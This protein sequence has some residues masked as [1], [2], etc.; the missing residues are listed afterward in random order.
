MKDGTSAR[1]GPRGFAGGTGE[2]A[3]APDRGVTE[4]SEGWSVIFCLLT[5]RT[6][7]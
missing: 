6:A 5:P 2:P 7:S 4:Q 3:A 1:R